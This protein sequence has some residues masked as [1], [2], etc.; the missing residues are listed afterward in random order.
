MIEQW[1]NQII[2]KQGFYADI[3][4]E[5]YHHNPFL[6][7]GPSISSSGLRSF[8]ER[9]SLYW[10]YSPYNS[11]RFEKPESNALSFGKAAHCL[12]LGEDDFNSRFSIRPETYTDDKGNVK[13]WNGNANVCKAWLADN[14]DKTV[15][16]QNDMKSIECI[17]DQLSQRTE[18]QSGLL[19][20]VIETSMIA[21]VE[22]IWLRARP[23]A[24]PMH[25]GDHADLKMTRASDYRDLERT[26]FQ[27]GYHIQAAVCRMVYRELVKDQ[28]FNYALVFCENTPPH[29]V[30]I[31]QLSDSAIDLG[32]RQVRLGL[33]YFRK[34]IDRMEW[35]S[36]EGFNPSIT[37]IGI[38]SWATTKTEIDLTYIEQEI[39]A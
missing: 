17:A 27:Y 22:E 24:I 1:N 13:P 8:I 18:I 37:T 6:C 31:H 20:G 39:A 30:Y 26:I 14:A 23:D 2:R 38:P 11:K 33:K 12:I 25:S 32:E 19:E 34:C 35:P 4:I 28:D 3:P 9:P 16:T 7:D 29:D 10:A 21:E 15:I 5:T 36:G